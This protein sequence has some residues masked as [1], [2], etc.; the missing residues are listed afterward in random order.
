MPLNGLRGRLDFLLSPLAAR[1]PRYF[2]SNVSVMHLHAHFHRASYA[3]LAKVS[4]PPEQSLS[5]PFSFPCARRLLTRD[6]PKRENR[7]ERK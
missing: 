1:P 6:G 4:F 5:L 3:L 2:G 7:S